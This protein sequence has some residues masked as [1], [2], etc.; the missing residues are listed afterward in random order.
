MG[1]VCTGDRGFGEL[2]R[3]VE[4]GEDEFEC[5]R[6]GFGSRDSFAG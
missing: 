2:K 6:R 4:G 1:E 5:G 3:V